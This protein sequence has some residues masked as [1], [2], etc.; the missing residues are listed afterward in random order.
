MFEIVLAQVTPMATPV[1]A[2]IDGVVR[3]TVDHEAWEKPAAIGAVVVGALAAIATGVLAFFTWKL[4]KETT[5]LARQSAKATDFEAVR[6]QRAARPIIV[7]KIMVSEHDITNRVFIQN[8]GAN[9][10][11]VSVSGHVQARAFY[12]AQNVF[13]MI[14]TYEPPHLTKINV[15]DIVQGASKIRIRYYDGFGNKYI[16]E[17]EILS[18]TIQFPVFRLPQLDKVKPRRWSE[19][20]TWAVEPIEL[21]PNMEP[22]A[23]DLVPPDQG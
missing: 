20:V 18:D 19:E 21:Y 9:A 5:D 11:R 2:A 16:T 12:A 6:E 15:P 4:A 23:L 22:E 17:Y 10:F 3:A 8:K 13:Q 7:A 1:H 14:G